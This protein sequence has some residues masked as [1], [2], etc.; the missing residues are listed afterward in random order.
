MRFSVLIPFLK[1]NTS[2]SWSEYKRFL[3]LPPSF[4]FETKPRIE[5]ADKR[6]LVTL[7]VRGEQMDIPGGLSGG[8]KGTVG[9]SGT[10]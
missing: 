5:D 9:F 6:F 2:I 3:R 10:N 7:C 4:L 8:N 1:Q